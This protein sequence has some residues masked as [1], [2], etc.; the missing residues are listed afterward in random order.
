M[1]LHNTL[2]KSLEEFVPVDKNR[3]KMYVCGPTTSG[4]PHIGNIRPAIIFDVLFRLLKHQYP[5]V[6]YASNYTDVDDKIINAT[7]SLGITCEELTKNSINRYETVLGL[8]NVIPPIRPR[9]TE[10]IPNMINMIQRIIEKGFAY[11]SNDHVYFAVESYEKHGKLANHNLD[12]LI[13]GHRVKISENK[14]HDADFVLWKPINE[15]KFHPGWDSPWSR[16]FPGWHIECSTMIEDVFNSSTIDIHGGGSDLIFPHHENEISQFECIHDKPLANYWIHCGM[17]L[18]DGKKMSKSLGNVVYA[19]DLKEHPEVL[20]L[21]MLMTH[22]RQPLDFT[23]S[24]MQQAKSMLDRF[25][26]ALD[27]VWMY[28]VEI[29]PP[30]IVLETLMNDINTPDAISLMHKVTDHI[31][32]SSITRDCNRAKTE[33]ARLK[34]NL[35]GIGNILGILQHSPDIY[36]ARIDEEITKLVSLRDEYRIK[37]D[38]INADKVRNELNERGIILE[39]LDGKTVWR[40]K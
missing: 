21:M 14:F 38:Y 4:E 8:L 23:A 35:L 13:A 9:A 30:A 1:K 12:D 37:K 27:I 31:M 29:T 6:K 24:K 11:V 28:D 10:Y 15:D 16:G 2:T 34:S 19:G 7:K 17:L 33:R 26:R 40:K 36:F 5:A 22:Y 20:R 18:V 39:D 32:K 3:I 25:Y